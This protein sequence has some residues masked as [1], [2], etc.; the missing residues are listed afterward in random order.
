MNFKIKFM[1]Y[2]AFL[3]CLFLSLFSFAQSSELIFEKEKGQNSLLSNSI[4]SITQDNTGFLWLGTEYGLV[5]FDGYTYI[6]FYASE[7]EEHSLPSNFIKRIIKSKNGDIWIGTDRGIAYVNTTLGQII[8]PDFCKNISHLQINTICE[9]REGNLWLGTNEGVKVVNPNFKKVISVL[10]GLNEQQSFNVNFIDIDKDG[11]IW[12][13]SNYGFCAIKKIAP[14]ELFSSKK[15]EGKFF[16]EKNR[17]GYFKIDSQNKLWINNDTKNYIFDIGSS[18]MLKN[19]LNLNVNIDGKCILILSKDDV[20]IG[21]RWNGITELTRNKEEIFVPTSKLWMNTNSTTD[22][23]N[24]VNVLFEDRVGNIWAGTKAGLYISRKSNHTPFHNIKAE[25]QKP[26]KLSHNAISSIIQS[27]NGELWIGT[28][29]GLNQLILQNGNIPSEPYF[30][31][32]NPNFAEF[33]TTT[34][35]TNLAIQC[36]I[37]D[38]N[39]HLWVGTKQ[40]IVYFDPQK[41]NFTE[42]KI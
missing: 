30:N 29:N 3:F 22:L 1:R 33:T 24:T 9:D 41:N 17:L 28:S 26:N 27:K 19:K 37:E 38:V 11:N 13:G 12:I 42:K 34:F 20:L 15:I 16:K 39:H 25:N 18:C 14:K 2:C 6:S 4:T 23:S 32:F 40:G 31:Y 5:R 8:K 7:N 21:S 36:L 35:S 10:I